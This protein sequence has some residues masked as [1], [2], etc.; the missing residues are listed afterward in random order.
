MATCHGYP[1]SDADA[2]RIRS[3]SPVTLP[4]ADRPVDLQ[5][6]ISGPA[7]G[8]ALPTILLSHGHGPS[9]YVSSLHG[10][11]PLAD[12]YAAHGFVVVQPTHLDSAGHGSPV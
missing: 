6:R 5:V 8:R 12:Y 7:E 3:V 10:Y 1:F 11:A 9:N 2:Q 4:A